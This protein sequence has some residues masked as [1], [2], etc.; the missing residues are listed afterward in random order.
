MRSELFTVVKNRVLVLCVMTPYN[1][2]TSWHNLRNKSVHNNSNIKVQIHRQAV[3]T[4]DFHIQPFDW[5]TIAT[6]GQTKHQNLSEWAHYEH[7]TLKCIFSTGGDRPT[8]RSVGTYRVLT[9]N[10]FPLPPEVRIGN[11]KWHADQKQQNLMSM[12]LYAYT[13]YMY[14]CMYVY[15]CIYVRMYIFMYAC[16]YYVYMY[17]R[18]FMYHVFMYVYVYMYVCRH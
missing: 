10:T 14:V 18:V 4:V 12:I 13:T 17:V 5:Y 2:T 1:V 16:A 15:V 3:A 6:E 9:E 7:F 8:D 11:Y